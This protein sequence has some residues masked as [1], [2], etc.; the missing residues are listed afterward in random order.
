MKEFTLQ[1]DLRVLFHPMLNTHSVTVGLYIKAGIAFGNE[2]SSG[3]THFLEHLHFRRCGKYSQSELYYKMESIGSALR[4]TT[5]H[6]LLQFQM[7]VSPEYISECMDIFENII[8]ADNWTEE[9]FNKE[10]KVVKNQIYEEGDYVDIDKESRKLVY[11]RHPLS[12]EIMGSAEDVDGITIDEAL[13]YKREI[14]NTSNMLMCI[15]GNV[16]EAVLR[17]N[18][19]NIEKLHIDNPGKSGVYSAPERFLKRRPDVKIKK[20]DDD[21]LLDVK[22][23]FDSLCDIKKKK[24]LDILNCILGEGVGSRLQM[25]VREE[26]GYTSDINS[27][28]EY[29]TGIAVLYIDFSV[30]KENLLLCVG[31]IGCILN[32][33]KNNITKRD[34]D[35]SLPFY[36]TNRFM[37]DDTE[38]MN[39]TLAQNRLMFGE[40]EQAISFDNNM[41][42]VQMLQKTATELFTKENL[43]ITVVGK[44]CKVTHKSIVGALG[45]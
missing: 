45:I 35:V 23:S 6:D 36:T 34:L 22:L 7:K 9:E 3:I 32:S 24:E 37:D 29:Y 8:V 15:T 13:Q 11:Y 39:F 5:Y 18:L 42:T 40:D 2:T 31:E 30:A 12:L 43:C 25:V 33:L 21:N 28:L 26:K 10:K 27:Y 41:E 38:E 20:V 1:N 16:D 19:S 4:A 17:K 44:T 14:F